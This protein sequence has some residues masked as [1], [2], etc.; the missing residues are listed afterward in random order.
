MMMT[1]LYTIIP[2]LLTHRLHGS[3]PQTVENSIQLPHRL[4]DGTISHTTLVCVASSCYVEQATLSL[5]I[6]LPEDLEC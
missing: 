4:C 6:C 2:I 1:D 5:E 3:I